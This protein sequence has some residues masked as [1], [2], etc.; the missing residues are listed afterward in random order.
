MAHARFAPGMSVRSTS[1]AKIVAKVRL[2]ALTAM[3]RSRCLLG[4]DRVPG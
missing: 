1:Q 2:M 4:P 3:R